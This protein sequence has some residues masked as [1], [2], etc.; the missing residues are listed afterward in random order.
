[1]A[2]DATISHRGFSSP[3]VTAPLDRREAGVGQIVMHRSRDLI[4]VFCEDA[5]GRKLGGAMTRR[6]FRRLLSM[7]QALLAEGEDGSVG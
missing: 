5:G 3:T 7:A 6:A 2:R 4:V 1:M